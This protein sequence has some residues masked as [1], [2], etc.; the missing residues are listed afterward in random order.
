MNEQD[1]LA[2][3]AARVR[4]DLAMIDYPEP[5]WVQPRPGALDVVIAGAGQGG[6]V[7]AFALLRERVG[8]ILVIDRAPEGG[9]GPWRNYARMLTLRSPKATTGPDL[10][11]PSLTY[12][13]WHEAQWGAADYA[14]LVK[15]PTGNW[16]DYLAWYRK[17][18][19]IPLR[20]ETELQRIE[21]QADGLLRLH[22]SGDRAL[23]TRKLV[24]A[25]GIE[26][27]GRWWA[28]EAVERLP[29]AF[30]AHSCER[31]DFAALRGKRVAV[32]GAGASAF[33]NA[34]TAL[35]AGA[36]RVE[37]C[38]RAPQLKRL[39]PF[40]WMS[41]C[42]FMR[43]VHTL[44]DAW[45]WRFLRH[46]LELREAFPKETWERVTRHG[47]FRLHEGSPWEQVEPAGDAVSIRTPKGRIEADYLIVA[48][49]LDVDL[50]RAPLL[51]PFADRIALWSDRYKPPPEERSERLARY[52]YL[53]P[54]LALTEKTPGAAPFLR[55]I[56]VFNWGSTMSF[57]PSGS[58][59]NGMK[60]A[61]PKLVH[62]LTR[63]LYMADLD[64]HWASLE[65]Y[66]TPEFEITEDQRRSVLAAD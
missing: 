20:S 1:G 11:I 64:A 53:G 33:D 21:P 66:D 52:P 7:T 31:I 62:G 17:V 37:L 45:R 26:S 18:L 43:H 3:L 47:N 61:V 19:G 58:S 28:P 55:D 34:A 57:G 14:A 63:D 60:F 24:L 22:L 25:T 38:A 9:E 39:Q 29:K 2:A 4:R 15:I 10:G 35:E 16:A 42:G 54:G 56:H 27:S 59:V 36:A 48:T 40:R 49:G 5:H 32:L 30:W 41:N 6:L 51:A 65:A 23:L 46:I 13:A 44:D 8:N 50:A 12:Q